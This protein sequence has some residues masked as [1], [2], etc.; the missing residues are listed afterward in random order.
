MEKEKD[1]VIAERIAKLVA[2]EGGRCYYV[3]GFVRDR[4]L[5]AETKDV[6]IEVHGV[7]P[8]VLEAILDSVGERLEYG[9]SFGIYG[10]KGNDIDIAMPRKEKCRGTGHKDFDVFVDP[11]IGTEKAAIRR[12]FT[13][14]AMM[15]DVLTGEVTDHF[16]GKE[17]LKNKCIRH[18]NDE[19]FSEDPLRVLRAAQFAS[20][21]KFSVHPETISLCRKMTLSDLPKERILGEMKKAL[22]KAEK[23]SVF[24]EVLREM[25]KLSDWFPEVEALIAVPQ[26]PVHH[27][28]GDVWTHTMMVLDAASLYREKVTNPLGFM[29][30]ALAH[31]FGKPIC[32]AEKNGVLHAYGHEEKGLPLSEKFITRL[33]SETALLRYVQNLCALHMKPNMLAAVNAPIKSTNKMFDAAEDREALLALAA[34]DVA[35]KK[36]AFDEEF[37]RQRLRIYEEY[38]ARPFVQ[39]RDLIKAG[40]QADANFSS[41]LDYAHKL[42]LAG[43][44]KAD[45]LRQTLSF[46]RKNGGKFQE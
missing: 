23:P 5:G 8:A 11:F 25:H 13:I 18:V 17:D 3:G 29:L 45:A 4:L 16:G 43:I 42:R 22:L 41:Y 15:Q 34:S 28:E 33:T 32:T 10:L 24:F 36:D 9:K 30:A 38:M 20:R 26:N 46:A 44:D 2:D 39:G 14:N 35:G 6:D 1:I 19:S 37:L 31:D 21:F 12:D 27:P 40:L 7:R